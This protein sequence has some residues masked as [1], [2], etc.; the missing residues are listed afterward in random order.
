MLVED[1]LDLARVDVVAAADDQLLLAVD[2]EEVAVLVDLAHVAAVEPAVDDG[3][4][5]R[6]LA[7]PV[8]L[9]DVVALDDDLADLAL[10]DLVAVVVEQLHLDALDRRADGADLALLVGV[11]EGGDRRGLAQP[12]ALEDLAVERLLEA[13]HQLAGHRRAAGAADP[14]RRVV[15]LL[16]RLVVEHRVVHR[17]HAGEQRHL[18]A[19]D[20]LQRL[21]GIEARDERQRR[22]ATAH[23]RSCSTSGR[24]NG[25]AAARRARRR[26]RRCRT[27]RATPARCLSMLSWVSSAPLGWPVVPDV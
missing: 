8:A 6:L 23:T 16:A 2:D 10:L 14:Q 22:A 24:R 15:A 13:A 21:G 26:R 19:L 5:G 3:L 1:L 12:V 11:V 20:D 27:G 4:L 17:R 18:V 9:H 25:T 7:V